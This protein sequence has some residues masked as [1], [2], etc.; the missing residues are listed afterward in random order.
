[1]L[2]ISIDTIIIYDNISIKE[3]SQGDQLCIMVEENKGESQMRLPA[4]G[5]TLKIQIT[6]TGG[7]EEILSLNSEDPFSMRSPDISY[8]YF[9]IITP[10]IIQTPNKNNGTP[11]FANE[12]D[13]MYFKY[14]SCLWPYYSVND[15]LYYI[16]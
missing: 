8:L 7:D 3:F 2:P 13:T 1:M 4:N 16:P 9:K 14:T 6:T 12:I 11:E 10:S 5:G 15:T